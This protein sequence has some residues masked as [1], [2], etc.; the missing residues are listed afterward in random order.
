MGFLARSAAAFALVLGLAAPAHAAGEGV[1]P[2]AQNWSFNG[3][4]GTIDRAAAQRGLQVYREVCATCHSLRLIAYRSLAGLGFSEDEIA[5]MAAQTTNYPAEP[6]DTGEV[7]TRPGLPADH[8]LPP[9]ANEQAARYANGGA[10]PP[11]LS[12][13][14]EAREGGA[15]YIYCFLT[16]F[17]EAPADVELMPGMNYNSCFP[18]H[19]VAMPNILSDGG[20]TYA[21]GHPATVAEQAH[22]VVTFLT[23]TAE[24]NMD[25]RKQTGVKVVLFLIVFAGM[26]YA[27]KRKV[28]SRLH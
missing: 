9:F 15:D 7:G 13:I 18:G 17:G 16:G 20:V 24:P 1:E 27:V 10:L 6:D 4:F 12:V 14:V 2:P 19:Q 22:D 28:W 21:G 23:W 26:M 25:E 11:D 5:A 8:F 3:I